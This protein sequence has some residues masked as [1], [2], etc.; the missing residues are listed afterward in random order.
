MF[1]RFDKIQP[2]SFTLREVIQYIKYLPNCL[3]S[4]DRLL[5]CTSDVSFSIHKARHI[6]SSDLR[7]TL[8][9]L[10]NQE[11]LYISCACIAKVTMSHFHHTLRVPRWKTKTTLVFTQQWRHVCFL[12]WPKWEHP[13][14]CGGNWY[15][16]NLQKKKKNRIIIF[17]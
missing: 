1:G 12:K 11:E 15:L 14:G 5:E 17:I 2:L 7:E 8:Q 6:R 16:V 4:D 9:H 3:L 13:L 10:T